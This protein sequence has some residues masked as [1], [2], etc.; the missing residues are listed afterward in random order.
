MTDVDIK[1]E[2][3]RGMR[4]MLLIII[5]LT[6][7]CCDVHIAGVRVWH[8]PAGQFA[9]FLRERREQRRGWPWE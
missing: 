8:S 4:K 3:R 5:A 1:K 2:R 9:D 7:T 6:F